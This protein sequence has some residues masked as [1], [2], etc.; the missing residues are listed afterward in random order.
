METIKDRIKILMQDTHS[1][2]RGFAVSM[3][4]SEMTLYMMFKN[5]EA[6]PSLNTINA[7]LK[8]YPEL[9]EVWLISGKGDMW[10]QSIISSRLTP[11]FV[12]N[13]NDTTDRIEKIIE[14]LGVSVRSFARIIGV[15]HHE[16]S[17]ILRPERYAPSNN[18]IV[19]ILAKYPEI[20]FDWLVNGNGKPI[21]RVKV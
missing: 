3:G 5:K 18:L 19:S 2:M 8:L 20:S 16:L 10:K 9:N 1:T 6:Q 11:D 12:K 15:P 17:N 4:M 7:I 21:T 14:V 13:T